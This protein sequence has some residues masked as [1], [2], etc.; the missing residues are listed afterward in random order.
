MP[1]VVWSVWFLT[2]TRSPAASAMPSMVCKPE[3]TILAVVA[4]RT[5]GL[6]ARSGFGLV[7]IG[8]SA[9]LTVAPRRSMVAMARS[10]SPVQRLVH[11]LRRH[12][13]VDA[14][15]LLHRVFRA[16]DVA[17][18]D[19]LLQLVQH[20]IFKRPGGGPQVHER[21]VLA[22]Q[23]N[24]VGAAAPPGMLLVGTAAVDEVEDLVDLAEGR[25]QYVG[26]AGAAVPVV[27]AED[28]VAGD[29]AGT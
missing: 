16:A 5:G 10:L 24:G 14:L 27:L 19:R 2:S 23:R 21:G 13:E 29:G 6:M 11:R 15:A 7:A 18:V 9:A 20:E 28:E 8:G 26:G 25:A 12:H 17:G 1:F 4:A 22:R 3:K